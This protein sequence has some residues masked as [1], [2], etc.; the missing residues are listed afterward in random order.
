MTGKESAMKVLFIGNSYTYFNDM[1]AL[2]AQLAA[3]SGKQAEVFTS[4]QGGRKL[5]AYADSTDSVTAALDA[6]L[7]KETFD[8]CFIQEQSLL[9]AADFGRFLLGL[10]CVTGKL[11]NRVGQQILYATWGRKNGSAEL[12]ARGWT[13]RS[14]TEQLADA[15][16]RAADRCGA[17]VSPVGRNFLTVAAAHPEIELY[18]PD[19]S[20]PSCAGSCLAA[21]THYHTAFGEFPAHPEVLSLSAEVLSAFRA[22]VCR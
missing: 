5:L 19:G 8:L 22:A 13:T 11:Q 3:A 2:F 18:A 17:R 12:T 21:L 15:Y 14:M 6:L 10:D 9:P 4:V 20:H 16:Q 1:P 7:A